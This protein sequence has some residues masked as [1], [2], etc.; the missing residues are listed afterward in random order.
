MINDGFLPFSYEEIIMSTSA[1]IA[2]VSPATQSLDI[3]SV[4]PYQVITLL[5]DG[6]L[7]RIDQAI[8]RVTEGEID[9][10]AM[11]VEKAIGI[12]GGLRNSL[13]LD[14]GDIATNLDALYDY[15][16]ARLQAIDT[17]TPLV[18]LDEVKNLLQEIDSGWKGIEKTIER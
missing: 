17:E 16:L 1:S 9:E 6:A 7:E 15:I 5:L 2:P 12:I 10:A 11:L 14:Q 3:D 18:T 8:R 13:D 4:T